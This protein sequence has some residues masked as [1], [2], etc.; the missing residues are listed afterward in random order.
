MHTE[1]DGKIIC[2]C[3]GCGEPTHTITQHLKQKHPAMTPEKYQ[4][5]FPGAPML[6][7]YAIGLLEARKAAAAAAAAETT[8]MAGD[9]TKPASLVPSGTSL[10][11]PFNEVFDLGKAKAALSERGD[12]IP[13]SV[14]SGHDQQEYV[15][16]VKDSYV[17]DIEETKNA[18][19]AIEKNYPLYVWGHKGCG[20]TEL[21]D[22]ICAR[23]NRALIRVQHTVDTEG[24]HIT[25]QWTVKDGS[26]HFELG[27]LPLAMLN[28]WVYNADEYDFGMP[29][30]LAI[31]QAVLEG[32]SLV[33]KE[34]PA[35][36]R[37]IKPHPNFRFC[38]TGNTNGSGDETGLYQGTLIQNSA[39]YDRFGMV[40]HKDYMDKK[41]ETQILMNTCGL[42]N[43]DATRMIEF[44]TLV[45]QAYASAKIG[46]TISPRTLIYASNIGM[47]RGSFRKGLALS[48][49][50]KLNS[51]D[52]EVCDGLAQRIFS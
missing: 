41:A 11:K 46:D 4:E 44:A 45:R 12:P 28:G 38:A 23:T 47:M 43:A 52:K 32:K 3:A 48:F 29:S 27:P 14:L 20:K 30:V 6:S 16:A 8:K 31:Y 7:K 36:M 19:L 13:I 42:E 26:T 22:Q 25:G 51:V 10:K 39:N 34:A 5:T 9:T 15:P 35:E 17:Y 50:S 24:S 33:I 2:Q 18:I 40:I 49:L 37:I 21:I 1:V